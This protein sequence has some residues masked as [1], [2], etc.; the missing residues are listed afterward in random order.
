MGARLFCCCPEST[1]NFLI[2]DAR[3]FTDLTNNFEFK[4][5][6]SNLVGEGGFGKVFKIKCKTT[7]KEYALKVIKKSSLRKTDE[8]LSEKGALKEN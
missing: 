2:P 6:R 3:P 8:N 5:E 7:S 1:P 4:K